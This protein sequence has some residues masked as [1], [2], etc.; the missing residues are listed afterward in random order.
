[1]AAQKLG[2]PPLPGSHRFMRTSIRTSHAFDARRHALRRFFHFLFKEG[3]RLGQSLAFLRRCLASA[4]RIDAAKLLLTLLS[5]SVTLLGR[6]PS[7]SRAQGKGSDLTPLKGAFVTCTFTCGL[8]RRF[9][10]LD[11]RWKALDLAMN[12]S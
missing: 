7:N 9:R 10:M 5:F 1:M 6:Y 3:F 4:L 11:M 2:P 12:L 8:T